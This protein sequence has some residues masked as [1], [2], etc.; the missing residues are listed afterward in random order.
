MAFVILP[1]LLRFNIIILFC[2]FFFFFFFTADPGQGPH[3][4]GR[5]TTDTIYLSGV[6]FSFYRCNVLKIG[7][8][9]YAIANGAYGIPIL[10]TEYLPTI[11]NM[12]SLHTMPELPTLMFVVLCGMI[13]SVVHQK[14]EVLFTIWKWKVIILCF[15]MYKI[16]NL[17]NKV[18]A[19]IHSRYFCFKVKSYMPVISMFIRLPVAFVLLDYFHISIRFRN[20]KYWIYQIICDLMVKRNKE[21]LRERESMLD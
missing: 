3:S 5:R 20:R 4:N 8:L 16:C 18:H 21:N 13:W 6:A 14:K 10:Y 15:Y 17:I 2:C 12:C 19:D 11:N 1:F 7:G 9:Q